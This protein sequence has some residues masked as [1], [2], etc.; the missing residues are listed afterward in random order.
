MLDS[1]SS[2]FC[3]IVLREKK[4]GRDMKRATLKFIKSNWLIDEP[5]LA[6]LLRLNIDSLLY[7]GIKTS[8]YTMGRGAGGNG[9]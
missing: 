9:A 4:T 6:G 2:S 1:F 8:G 5:N 7:A 3:N